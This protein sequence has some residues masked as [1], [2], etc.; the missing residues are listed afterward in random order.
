MKTV[1]LLLG[2][3][4]AVAFLFVLSAQTVLAD[5]HDGDHASDKNNNVG[6][7]FP[8]KD[9]QK[10]LT[11]ADKP[12]RKLNS[13]QSGKQGSGSNS[14]ATSSRNADPKTIGK[15]TGSPESTK[16]GSGTGWSRSSD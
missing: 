11:N 16:S 12:I 6:K 2:L 14:N 5:H 15:G 7:A 3:L 9:G 10:D 8:E 13:K 4:V 1:N